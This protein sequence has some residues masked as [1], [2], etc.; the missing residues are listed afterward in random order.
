MECFFKGINEQSS[1]SSEQLFAHQD[2]QRCPF[3][4]NINEPTSFS[5]SPI[6]FPMPVSYPL[7]SLL[8]VEKLAFTCSILVP[9]CVKMMFNMIPFLLTLANFFCFASDELLNLN[10]DLPF[11]CSSFSRDGEPKA[12]FSKM[13][14]ISTW[15]L[16]FSMAGVEWFHS[17]EDHFHI[18]RIC[19]LCLHLS[20]TH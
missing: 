14:P 7:L 12:P 2:I 13:A 11:H 5:F 15:H 16:G 17:L 9:E 10:D 4:R 6:K 19:S 3:L 18:L 8:S 20:S 1:S